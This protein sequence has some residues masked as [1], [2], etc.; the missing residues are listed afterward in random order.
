MICIVE[1]NFNLT[2]EN[3]ENEYV[4]HSD[5]GAY[6]ILTYAACDEL[7]KT[8]GISKENYWFMEA[9]FDYQRP[10]KPGVKSRKILILIP[11]DVWFKLWNDNLEDPNEPIRF[12]QGTPKRYLK[13]F[14]MSIDMA[15]QNSSISD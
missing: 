1:T 10:L 4:D 11:L 3:I 15:K 14:S 12:L 6:D 7:E 8:M 5:G 9:G 2:R 13:L